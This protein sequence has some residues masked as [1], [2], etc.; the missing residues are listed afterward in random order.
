MKY[1]VMF[2]LAFAFVFSACSKKT[3]TKLEAFSPEAFAYNMGDSSEVDATTRVKG[4]EQQQENGLYK[5]TIAYEID[6]VT[7]A[8]DTIK[9]LLSRVVDRSKKEKMTD[10]PLEAQFDLDSTYKNGNY[11]LI[12]R[13]KDVNS[14]QT[15]TSTASFDLGN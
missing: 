8:K 12:Y 10:T 3:E 15:A 9:S 6:L 5:A 11:N 2:L 4:F 13:I 14:G 7:P 1:A